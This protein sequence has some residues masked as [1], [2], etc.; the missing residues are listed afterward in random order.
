MIDL[1]EHIF[2]ILESIENNEIS[3]LDSKERE[4]IKFLSSGP[5]LMTELHELFPSELS[6]SHKTKLVRDMVNNINIKSITFGQELVL[7]GND[8][9][10]SRRK[11]FYLNNLGRNTVS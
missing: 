1:Q 9:I 7:V 2:K 3:L 6:Q 4:L 10:D 8:E 11:V 5:K